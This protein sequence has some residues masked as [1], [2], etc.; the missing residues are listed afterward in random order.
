MPS[1]PRSPPLAT[2]AVQDEYFSDSWNKK[3]KGGAAYTISESVRDFLCEKLITV[4]LSERK[5]VKQD[6]VEV[7]AY[8]D[9]NGLVSPRLLEEWMEIWDYAG[10]LRF[11]G[12]VGGEGYMRGLFVF[13]DSTMVGKD[14]KPG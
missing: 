6:C 8:L 4:F 9:K 5:A 1:P 11:R 12:F 13:F 10:D 2:N 7:G 3:Q 14:L